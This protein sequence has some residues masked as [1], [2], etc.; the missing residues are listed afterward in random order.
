MSDYGTMI[1]RIADE[2]SSPV[3][4]NRIPNA[5]QAAIRYFESERFWFNEGES[6]AS[7]VIS[8]ASYA[9]PTDFLEPDLLTLT[10]TDENVRYILTRRPWE[11]LRSHLI[12]PDTVAR[13]D[14][15]AYYADQIWLFPIPDQVYTLTLSFLKRQSALSAYT[16]TNDWMVHGEELIRSRAKWDLLMHS[17][18][19]KD[20]NMIQ[21][22]E[23]AE[24]RALFNLRGKSEQKIASGKLS[25]DDGLI[26]T[27][28]H[29]NINYQ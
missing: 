2:L 19:E 9:M 28:G 4:V 22:M 11:W 17:M 16:D 8:Q 21:A 6:T 24:R 14:D 18:P 26:V 12:D 3:I 5:I 1:A 27:R 25:F 15:W 23:R 7:T 20:H 13:P 10:D 29:Y